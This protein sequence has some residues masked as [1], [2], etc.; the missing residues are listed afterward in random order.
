MSYVET[1]KVDQKK[2]IELMVKSMVKRG[3]TNKF[4]QAGILAIVSKESNLRP[5]SEGGYGG[6]DN[7]RIRKI[8]GSRVQN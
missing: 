8:F 2:A 3:I 7:A 1:L 5:K 4:M 6:T